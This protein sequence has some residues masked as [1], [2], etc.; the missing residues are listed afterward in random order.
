MQTLPPAV[1]DAL[2]KGNLMEAIKLLRSSGIGLKE[3]KDAI[4]AHARGKPAA[5][6]PTFSPAATGQSLPP[7]VVDA[8]QK[9]QKIEAIRLMREQTGLGLKEAKDAVDAYQQIYRP[10]DGLSPGQVSDTGSGVWWVIGLV[11]VCLVGYMVLR[12][13]G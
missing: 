10:A 13:L 9:G 1:I 11:L 4:E 8:L 12:R 5:H 3:A 2:S 7:N 6:A